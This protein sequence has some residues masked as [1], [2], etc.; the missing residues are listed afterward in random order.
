MGMLFNIPLLILQ[1]IY[2]NAKSL[3]FFNKNTIIRDIY[4]MLRWQVLY[5]GR[6]CN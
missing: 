1:K 4:L 3:L 6:L 2:N 5:L